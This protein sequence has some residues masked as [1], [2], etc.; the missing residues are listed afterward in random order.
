MQVPLVLS[1]RGLDEHI[2]KENLEKLVRERTGK[3]ERYNRHIISCRVAVEQRHKHK[4]SGNPCRVRIDVTVPPHHE[5]VVDREPKKG[6]LP[7]TTLIRDAFMAMERQ[8]KQLAQ[9]Q[10]NE[11]K[12]HQ[13]ELKPK[14]WVV[15]DEE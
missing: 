5:I 7:V 4:H 8:L 13:N 3:L 14:E 2:N 9:K 10:R 12:T 11:V 1:F 15:V 6:N